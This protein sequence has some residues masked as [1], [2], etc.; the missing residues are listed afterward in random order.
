MKGRY[1]WVW[2]LVAALLLAPSALAGEQP[3]LN[4]GVYVAYLPTTPYTMRATLTVQDG[5]AVQLDMEEFHNP[6]FWGSLTEEEALAMGEGLYQVI[7]NANG[8]K[9]YF[10]KYLTVGTGDEAI[11]WI[12]PDEPVD[13]GLGTLQFIYASEAA[14]AFPAWVEVYENV[15]WYDAQLSAGSY[16]I[17]D[18]SGTPID[19]LKTYTVIQRNGDVVPKEGARYKTQNRHW[20]A[21]GT[22]FGTESG[23]LGWLGNMEV[24]SAFLIENQFPKG[25]LEFN[26]D[27]VITIADA[28]T[29]ATLTSGIESYFPVAYQAYEMALAE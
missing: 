21:V 12:A 2:L 20:T 8:R 19:D 15:A 18:E 1:L 23:E 27:K 13:N 16:W 28:V 17:T 5:V 3:K 9:S 14:G 29:G 6:A 24:I 25:E 26:S 11:R 22:G 10:G 4:D 7:E